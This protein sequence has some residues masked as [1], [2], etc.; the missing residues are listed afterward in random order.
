M[1]ILPSQLG[2]DV[3]YDGITGTLFS[4]VGSVI[5]DLNW[6][7]FF[8]DHN[9]GAI[10]GRY[11]SNDYMDALGYWYSPTYLDRRPNFYT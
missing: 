7:Q 10:I 4:D 11:D 2:F 1:E 3:G 5:V 6:Q 8:N 9:S